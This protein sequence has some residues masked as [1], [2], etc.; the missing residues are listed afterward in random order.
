[1]D[2]IKTV[3]I[4]HNA[5]EAELIEWLMAN[6]SNS[7]AGTY[8]FA[9]KELAVRLGYVPKQQNVKARKK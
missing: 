2:P 4:K 1:M 8:K 6:Q 5:E 9:A 7:G 3:L